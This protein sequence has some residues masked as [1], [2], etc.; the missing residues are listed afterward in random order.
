MGTKETPRE[1][2]DGEQVAPDGPD[3]P[4]DEGGEVWNRRQMEFDNTGTEREGTGREAF[5]PDLGDVPETESADMEH[6]SGRGNPSGESHWD[7]VDD[8]SR[9]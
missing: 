5:P 7:R 4:L 6:I 9:D 3:E 8:T 1:H 2:W